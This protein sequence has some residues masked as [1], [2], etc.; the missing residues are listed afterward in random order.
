MSVQPIP[1]EYTT[2]TPY[3]ILNDAAK[4][5]AFYLD[6][7]GA[8]EAMRLADPSGKVMHAEIRINGSPIMLADEFPEM[9]FKS[10]MTIGGSPVSLHLY[11]EDV[12]AFVDRAVKAGATLT[13]P[14]ANQFYGERS[15]GFEDPFGHVWHI[16]TRVEDLSPEEMQTRFEAAMKSG[17]PQ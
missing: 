5:I 9:G 3:L 13:R 14:V 17:T 2:V 10:P 7:L 11:V 6:A 8:T 4:A 12:D 16:A 15:G 1:K